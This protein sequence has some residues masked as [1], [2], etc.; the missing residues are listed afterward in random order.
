MAPPNRT[1]PRT[2]S[3]IPP[4][5]ASSTS[6]STPPR[7]P[8]PYPQTATEKLAAHSALSQAKTGFVMRRTQVWAPMEGADFF[9]GGIGSPKLLPVVDEGWYV[10]MYWTKASRPAWG[11]PMILRLPGSDRAVVVSAGHEAG[12]GNL[13][14]V[15]GTPEETHFYLGTKHLS[16]MQIGLAVDGTLPFGPRICTD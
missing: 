9:G 7:T 5:T 13:A 16:V 3:T 10:D 11:T 8:P 4:P 1:P 6:R 15:G 12:P 14:H 2:P